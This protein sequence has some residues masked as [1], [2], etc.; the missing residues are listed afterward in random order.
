[1]QIVMVSLVEGADRVLSAYD[2]GRV[3]EYWDTAQAQASWRTV[4]Q[5]VVRDH[6]EE[7]LEVLA[8]DLAQRVKLVWGT[9]GIKPEH[10]QFRVSAQGAKDG[11]FWMQFSDVRTKWHKVKDL[12][13]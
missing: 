5:A 1:M 12:L 6:E 3:K 10:F 9:E 11:R 8:D 7:A 2:Y 4:L 13:P